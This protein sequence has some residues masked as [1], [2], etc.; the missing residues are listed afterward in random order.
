MNLALQ[1][2]FAVAKE[3]PD[4]L[5]H[6][7]QH[8]HAVHIQFNRKGDYLALGLSDGT[9]VIYDLVSFAIV[10]V[11]QK[12]GHVRPVT[13]LTWSHC[14]RYLLSSSQDW[15]CILWDLA[16]ANQ[17]TN[18]NA[19]VHRLVVAKVQF[20]GPI[21]QACLHPTTPFVF[22][23]C[24]YENDPVCVRVDA[25]TGGVDVT[26]LA[27]EPVSRTL[28]AGENPVPTTQG[29]HLTL[30]AVFSTTGAHV[31]AGTSKGWLNV[32]DTASGTSVHLVKVA[33]ANIKSI[34]VAP[35]GRKLAVN[36]LDRIIRQITLPDML[37][38]SDP[39][40]WEFEVE[41]KYQDVVNRLQWNTVQF[42]HNADFLVASTF[43][44]SSQDLYVWE[45]AMGLLVKILEGSHEELIDVKW[46]YNRCTIGATGLDSGTVYLWLVQFPLKWSALAPDFVEIDENEEYEEK[47]DEFD[48]IDETDLI[49]KR[50]EEEDADIDIL[51]CEST[52][53][54]GFDTQI[55]SFVIPINYETSVV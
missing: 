44:Q 24:L 1:D 29:K 43:G 7:L 40:Q 20:D 23:A 52:D 39:S 17:G 4:T 21:W 42:N 11:L 16:G 22:T 36:S 53:V 26:C 33:N 38:H 14:G 54:R 32:I 51:L 15:S 28:A 12:E 13:S 10:C 31:I 48:I 3:Y 49:K 8:G 27:T 35:N 2:P 50:M 37:N 41:C 47:E 30:C 34:A 55:D 5:V 18:T 9:I 25:D 19:R 6:T 45:T 46:N